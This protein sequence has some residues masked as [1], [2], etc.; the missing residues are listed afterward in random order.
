MAT[1]VHKATL[2][3]QDVELPACH[4]TMVMPM[5]PGKDLNLNEVKWLIHAMEKEIAAETSSLKRGR[6]SG[7]SPLHAAVARLKEIAPESAEGDEPVLAERAFNEIMRS[8]PG[9]AP[10][11]QRVPSFEEVAKSRARS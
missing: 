5:P 8:R 3:G 11:R 10:A 9:L 2:N 7:P 1:K 6:A 4:A